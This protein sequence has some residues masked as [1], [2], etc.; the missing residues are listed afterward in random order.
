MEV[1][2]VLRSNREAGVHVLVH[3]QVIEYG[4]F[5]EGAAPSVVLEYRLFPVAVEHDVRRVLGGE[6]APLP[7]W[8]RVAGRKRAKDRRK[9]RLSPTVFGIDQRK[10]RKRNVRAGIYRI[11]HADVSDELKPVNHRPALRRPSLLCNRRRVGGHGVP[12][13][14]PRFLD[15]AV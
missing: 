7:D 8:N 11:E 1:L 14:E 13:S 10:S 12:D 9:R 4:H 15:R 6:A 2:T 3:E 5:W